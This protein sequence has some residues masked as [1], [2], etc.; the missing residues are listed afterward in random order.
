MGEGPGAVDVTLTK[1]FML[2]Q[3]EVTQGQ[4]R[5]VM[6][7]NPCKGKLYV[8]IHDDAAVTYVTWHDAVAFCEKLT[9]REHAHGVLPLTQQYRLPTHG[10]WEYA[11]RAGTHGMFSFGD[12][13]SMLGSYAWYGSGWDAASQMPIPGGNTATS[14]YAHIVGEK[15]ANNW[16][17]FDIHGNVFEWIGSHGHLPFAASQEGLLSPAGGTKTCR[18]GSWLLGQMPCRSAS[19]KQFAASGVSGDLGFRIAISLT[20]D[21]ASDSATSESSE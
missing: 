7:T 5:E 14:M 19:H 8:I 11:C 2:G 4:W 6:G 9:E 13:E 15:K 1:P 21:G 18:G 10:E 17:L 12:D 3:T 16:G 20:G